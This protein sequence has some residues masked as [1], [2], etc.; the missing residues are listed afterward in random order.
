MTNETTTRNILLY[1]CSHEDKDWDQ[2]ERNPRIRVAEAVHA[3]FSGPEFAVHCGDVTGLQKVTPENQSEVIRTL[4]DLYRS[5]QESEKSGHG[6]CLPEYGIQGNHEGHA[7]LSETQPP[8]GVYQAL[9]NEMKKFSGAD[10]DPSFTEHGTEFNFEIWT[11]TFGSTMFIGVSDRNDHDAPWGKH[12]SEFTGGHPSGSISRITIEKLIHLL[13]INRDRDI[14]VVTHQGWPETVVGSGFD[15]DWPGHNDRPFSVKHGKGTILGFVDTSQKP[16]VALE[17]KTLLK[18]LLYR[19][20]RL[21]TAVFSAHTHCPV[22]MTAKGRTHFSLENKTLC[23]NVGSATLCHGTVKMSPSCSVLE[24]K[25]GSNVAEIDRVLVEA[26]EVDEKA[27][28]RGSVFEPY[29][30]ELDLKNAFT[31]TYEP[32]DISRPETVTDLELTGNTK[33][34]FN[35]K[36]DG[37]LVLAGTHAIEW[38]P[39]DGDAHFAPEHEVAPGQTLLFVTDA[40]S[41]ELSCAAGHLKI[42]PFNGGGGNILYGSSACLSF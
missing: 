5:F 11:K 32:A 38:E 13:L 29:R 27:Y 22:G 1:G 36:A 9:Y 16:Q 30:Q 33:V 23:V 26:H 31:E 34:T 4:L 2:V 12:E 14:F 6:R 21:I 3:T 18:N 42:V 25:P 37:Y 39:T 20:D 24:L 7:A 35:G 15:N 17:S 41:F 10:S 40:T 8:N 19:S 28:P